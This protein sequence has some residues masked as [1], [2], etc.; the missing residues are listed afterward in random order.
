MGTIKNFIEKIK[1]A[2]YGKDVRQSIV[3]AIEQTYD[4]AIAN[5]HTDMEVAKAR[6]TYNDLNSRLEADKNKMEEKIKNEG[7]DRKEAL[8]DIQKQVNGLASGSPKGTFETKSALETANPETG[9]YIISKDGHIYSWNKGGSTAIDLGLYQATG[10]EDNSVTPQKTT[11]AVKNKINQI[12][13]SNNWYLNKSY[14]TTINQSNIVDKPGYICSSIYNISD[15]LS[16]RATSN[17]LVYFFKEDKTFLSYIN[18]GWTDN[19]LENITIPENALYFAVAFFISNTI[20]DEEKLALWNSGV[21]DNTFA[22]IYKESFDNADFSLEGK[23]TIPNLYIKDLE[24]C[25]SNIDNL[26]NIVSKK[27]IKEKGVTYP[28]RLNNVVNSTAIEDENIK[29]VN[30]T[31]RVTF[32]KNSTVKQILSENVNIDNSITFVFY[33]DT[34]SYENLTKLNI[35]LGTNLT[36]SNYTSGHKRELWKTLFKEGW[37]FTKIIKK[38]FSNSSSLISFNSIYIESVARSR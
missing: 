25:K 24:F 13:L 35:Y 28:F 14:N 37:N 4:D 6:D 15:S 23:I 7:A 9:V 34:K 38:D 19:V 2:R 33:I 16:I 8:E 36:D 3:D 32:S 12:N 11:F 22:I 21:R 27:L 26:E 30:N 17:F 31:Y 29:K 20:T 18:S 10:I 1:S 5:G